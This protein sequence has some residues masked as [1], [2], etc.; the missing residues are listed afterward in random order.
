V[1]LFIDPGAKFE[2]ANTPFEFPSAIPYDMFE[3]V[4]GDKSH[5]VEG[6]GVEQIFKGWAKRGLADEDILSKGF[7]CF[8]ALYAEFK[9]R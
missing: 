4:E 2:F 1:N 5:R 6:F 3:V 9:K 8:D 7:E